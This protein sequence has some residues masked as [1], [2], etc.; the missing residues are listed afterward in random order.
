[1]CTVFNTVCVFINTH[2]DCCM[3]AHKHRETLS[4]VL[5]E[6]ALAFTYRHTRTHNYKAT[7]VNDFIFLWSIH[8]RISKVQCCMSKIHIPWVKWI[9]IYKQKKI[10]KIVYQHSV[11]CLIHSFRDLKIQLKNKFYLKIHKNQIPQAS[12][13]QKTEIIPLWFCETVIIFCKPSI[14]CCQFQLYAFE[15][16]KVPGYVDYFFVAVIKWQF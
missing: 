4:V 9:Q 6:F 1:M 11:Y 14:C 13:G 5:C 8:Q 15:F 7:H 16:P 10:N 12:L 2:I 3:I